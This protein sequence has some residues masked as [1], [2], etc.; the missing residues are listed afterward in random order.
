MTKK[1]LI[2]GPW[3]G[4]FGWELFAWHGYVRTLAKQYDRIIIIL[5]LALIYLEHTCLLECSADIWYQVQLASTPP[6]E[7]GRES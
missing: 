5:L 4:E 7:P 6:S 2:A 3:V 1:T